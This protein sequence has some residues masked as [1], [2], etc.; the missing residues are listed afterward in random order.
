VGDHH[1][2][3]HAAAAEERAAQ[4]AALAAL[5]TEPMEAGLAQPLAD[6]PVMPSPRMLTP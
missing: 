5:H 6:H 2:P 3:D 4:V 1:P